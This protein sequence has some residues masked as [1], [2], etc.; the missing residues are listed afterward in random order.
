MK[1]YAGNARSYRGL[2]YRVSSSLAL[3]PSSPPGELAEARPQDDTRSGF[4]L[5]RT[6]AALT[7]NGRFGIDSPRLCWKGVI[8]GRSLS[9]QEFERIASLYPPW[10]RYLVAPA[11]SLEVQGRIGTM[12]TA[13]AGDPFTILELTARYTNVLRFLSGIL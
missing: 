1:K 13:F 2:N 7:E 10:R 3:T 12:L 8:L 5:Q 11:L 4:L 6:I 9:C